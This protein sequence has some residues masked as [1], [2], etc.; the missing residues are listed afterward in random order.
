[1]QWFN[2]RPHEAER[3]PDVQADPHHG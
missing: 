3:Q 2:A 1:V